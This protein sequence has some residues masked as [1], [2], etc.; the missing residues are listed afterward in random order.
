MKHEVHLALEHIKALI[1]SGQDYNIT[2]VAK[3]YG[4]ARESLSKA[5]KREG[6]TK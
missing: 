6:I 2:A 1:K 5:L 4:I 3:T